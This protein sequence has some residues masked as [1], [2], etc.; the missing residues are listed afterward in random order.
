MA[1]VRIEINSEGI[2]ELLHVVGETVC[3][4][5]AADVAGSL[6]E[7]YGSDVYDAGGRN[8]ASV[9][10][11]TMEALKDNYENNTLLRAMGNGGN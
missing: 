9:Y 2:R 6:G 8:V 5:I 11:S 4:P 7:G 10:I 1:Q 3:G